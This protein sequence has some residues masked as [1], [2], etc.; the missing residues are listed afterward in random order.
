MNVSARLTAIVRLVFVSTLLVAVVTVSVSPAV[1]QTD[2]PDWAADMFDRMEPMVETY[3][4]NVN[5]DDA[6]IAGDQLKNEN[7]NL[8]VSDNGTTAAVS[9]RLDGQLRMQN[10]SEGTRD[11]ATMK[12][13]TDRDTIERIIAATDPSTAFQSAVRDG[14]ITI[15]GLGTVN[16]VKWVV[17]NTISGFLR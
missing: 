16:A 1:A 14:D 2:Q 9:F 3:N 13:S 5:A 8:V 17:L 10:L 7:V 12:M 11:D 6:G 4:E 15:D